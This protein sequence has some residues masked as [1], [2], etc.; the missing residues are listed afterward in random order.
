[1]EFIDYSPHTQLSYYVDFHP[2]ESF[3][4]RTEQDIEPFLNYTER[5][6]NEGI[7][8]SGVKGEYFWYAV[9]PNLVKVKL[10]E[11]GYNFYTQDETEQKKIRKIIAS[12]YP[13]CKTTYLK[14]V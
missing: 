9:I 11:R 5:L 8:D 13:Y 3:T 4:I 2:D 7:C 10:K 12:D 14:H 1:M 6:R